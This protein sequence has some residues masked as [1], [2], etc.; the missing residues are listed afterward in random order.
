MPL[1]I[2]FEFGPARRQ[3]APLQK[4][5]FP[6]VLP[7]WAV[8]AVAPGTLTVHS[9]PAVFPV[10]DTKESGRLAVVFAITAVPI[11]KDDDPAPNEVPVK[12]QASKM[13]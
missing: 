9:S 3:V 12:Q 1:E 8:T 2:V 11:L 6:A 7:A 10:P 5:V 13:A 4:R